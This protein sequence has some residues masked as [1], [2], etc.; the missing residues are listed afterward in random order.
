MKAS[1]HPVEK[2]RMMDT[3]ELVEVAVNTW[4]ARDNDGF[5]ALFDEDCEITIP[6]GVVLRGA[7]G[8]QMFW[9]GYHNAFPDNQVVPAHGDQQRRRGHREDRV[10]GHPHRPAA[11]PRTAARSRR[12]ADTS[13]FPS[14]VSPPSVPTR[15]SATGCTSTRSSCSPRSASCPRRPRRA[16][17]VANIHLRHTT[18]RAQAAA[19]IADTTAD[20]VVDLGR[21][22]PPGRPV[23]PRCRPTHPPTAPR[24][25]HDLRRP[26]AF[27]LVGAGRMGQSTAIT[28]ATARRATGH[29][30]LIEQSQRQGTNTEE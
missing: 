21:A 3:T 14:S 27:L 4:N 10:R 8:A 23:H 29:R 15:S 6:G 26:V 25:L 20:Y 2:E 22:G 24:P 13:P 7:E 9:H 18:I 11:V 12:P 17:R 5:A 19:L 28:P 30:C 16:D 1:I